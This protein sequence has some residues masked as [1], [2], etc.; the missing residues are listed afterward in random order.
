M[1]AGVASAST[2]ARL[3][4][5]SDVGTLSVSDALTLRDAFE[6]TCQLRLEHQVAQIERGLEPG[7]VI[8]LNELSPLNRSYLKEAFRAVVS[9]QRR[10]AND[11][12]WN[13]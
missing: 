9:V 11:M 3:S 8:A 7:D 4:A 6:L 5:A 2:L 12:S 1:A 13:L 10:V